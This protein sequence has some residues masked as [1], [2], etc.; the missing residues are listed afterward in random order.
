MSS[1]LTPPDN[2]NGGFTQL[3]HGRPK[4]FTPAAR[5][6]RLVS[7]CNIPTFREHQTNG[8]FCHRGG[9]TP[10]NPG[11]NHVCRSGSV[12]VDVFQTSPRHCNQLQ[13]FG[14]FNDCFAHRCEVH[15][16][17]VYVPDGRQDFC[18]WLHCI[19]AI[20]LHHLLESVLFGLVQIPFDG[21]QL[22]VGKSFIRLCLCPP[23]L[24]ISRRWNELVPNNQNPKHQDLSY[25]N[26]WCGNP[27]PPWC[28]WLL[29]QCTQRKTLD[30]SLLGNPTSNHHRCNS[31]CSGC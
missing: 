10:H 16:D 20:P 5:F 22:N 23:L 13:V 12:L 2:S 7:A 26:P 4:R 17:G 31:K 6:N 14:R 19:R 25:I 18:G 21:D 9:V 1:Y 3:D 28:A 15:H 27:T 8:K 29:L 30:E 11:D 24:H